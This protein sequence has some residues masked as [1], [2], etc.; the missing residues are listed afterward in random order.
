MRRLEPLG[1]QRSGAALRRRRRRRQHGT[2]T[3]VGVA[4]K[5]MLRRQRQ[6]RVEQQLR[7]DAGGRAPR[8]Q[9]QRGRVLSEQLVH[10]VAGVEAVGVQVGQQVRRRVD[11]RPH[12]DVGAGVV[13]RRGASQRL[14]G[15]RRLR[16]R[17]L[18]RAARLGAAVADFGA[19]H[20]LAAARSPQQR[21]LLGGTTARVGRGQG[22][23]TCNT[24][25]QWLDN[26]NTGLLK[27]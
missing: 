19:V 8:E 4:E 22:E 16:E 27:I 7:V 13:G 15:R 14:L 23:P 17:R 21:L 25:R 3:G 24:M 5:R 26:V 18:R 9:R 11:R 1:Q 10:V 6:L 20:V 12:R 2:Q